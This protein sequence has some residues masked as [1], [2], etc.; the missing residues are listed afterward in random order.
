MIYPIVIFYIWSYPFVKNIYEVAFII[1]TV[2]VIIIST[3]GVAI[4]IKDNGSDRK[5]D[6]ICE[7][8]TGGSGIY[9][10]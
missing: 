5:V 1:T 7:V 6:I 3:M 10:N 4:T 8:N 9:L 2:M